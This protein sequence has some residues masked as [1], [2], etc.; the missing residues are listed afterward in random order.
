MI[1]QLNISVTWDLLR[2]Q[3]HLL[4]LQVFFDYG[5]DN[6][7]TEIK[8]EE[9]LDED[10]LSIKMETDNVEETIKQEEGIQD[11]DPL[12]CEQ[13]SDEDRIN[14]LDIVEH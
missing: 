14:T 1:N 13:I 12:S 11:K 5:E 6:I 9:T 8:E 7:K 3:F 10:P 2:I 4:L